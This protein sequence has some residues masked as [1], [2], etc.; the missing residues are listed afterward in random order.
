MYVYL[1]LCCL[2]K[3]NIFTLLEIVYVK[4][5]VLICGLNKI[6]KNSRWLWNDRTIVR[7]LRVLRRDRGPRL[8]YLLIFINRSWGRCFWRWWFSRISRGFA[9][10]RTCLKTNDT[11]QLRG[12][13]KC[14]S[15]RTM[16]LW[17]YCLRKHHVSLQHGSV[18]YQ[19]V[20]AKFK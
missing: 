5:R 11:K 8:L 9:L 3:Y 14:R 7:S 13:V 19:Y 20:C 4:C 16:G 17:H 1:C 2:V 10:K 12:Q 6:E 18:L 15:L